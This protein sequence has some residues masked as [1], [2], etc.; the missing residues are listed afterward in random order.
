MK[1]LQFSDSHLGFIQYGNTQRLKDFA[2]V[3][4]QIFEIAVASNV[5]VVVDAGDTFNSPSPDP[6]SIAA[7]RR[8]VSRLEKF[9]IGFAGI[10]GNHNRHEIQSRIPEVSWF[11]AVGDSII[12]P[13]RPESPLTIL[14]R[15]DD[16]DE[17]SVVLADW[18][19]SSEITEFLS[20]IPYQV[21]ALFMHQS[22]SEFLPDIS[23]PEID[24]V[25]LDGIARYVG[26]GD[27]HVTKTV[28]TPQGT[29]V[30]SSGSTE[31]NKRDEESSKYVF[32]VEI[33]TRDRQKQAKVDRIKLNTRPVVTFPSINAAEQIPLMLQR[34]R[35]EMQNLSLTPMVVVAYNRMFRPEMEAAE[36]ILREDGVQIVNFIPESSIATE[37]EMQE[38]TTA[39]SLEMTAIISESEDLKD[40]PE[41]MELAQVLWSA[42][43]NSK[44]I[45]EQ[46]RNK[47]T[48]ED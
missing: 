44:H 37:E 26:I 28:V 13:G 33:D 24:I 32:I 12:R 23:R 6:Y 1:I 14:S 42:P 20:K 3:L 10:I 29:V 16:D 30:G 22:C 17:M 41:A 19:P 47:T 36:K 31:M 38:I 21:D 25:Q 5:D 45:L 18:M 46:F 48:N 4:D 7:M 39:G 11:D 15:K 40:D 2:S 27:V 9:Q 34:V 35:S 8:F 43:H